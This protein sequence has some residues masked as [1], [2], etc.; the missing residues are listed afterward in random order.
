MLSVSPQFLTTIR[1]SHTV[2]ITADIWFQNTI[3]SRNIPI[4]DGQVTI[5]S[6]TGVRR[7]LDINIPDT[8][9]WGLLSTPG[10]QVRP[11]RGVRYAGGEVE[12]V[13][14]GVFMVD[15]VSRSAA[16]DGTISVSSAPDR[17]SY[18]QRARFETPQ[19][20]IASN[21][22]KQEIARLV[23]GAINVGVTTTATSTALAG[24]LTYEQDREVPIN[25]L[26][27]AIGAEAYFDTAG[28]LVIADAPL[29]GSGAVWSIDAGENGILIDGNRRRD[30]TRTYNV[31]V[32]TVAALDGQVVPE[33][34]VVADTDATS[35]TYIGGAMGRVPYFYESPVFLDTGQMLAAGKAILNKVKGVNAQLDV[36][37]VVNPALDR[38]DVV[39][40]RTA[41]GTAERHMVMGLTIPL[42][43]DGVQ[44]ITTQSSRPDGDVPGGE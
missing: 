9:L 23:T 2:E 8:S 13:P 16:N 20:S 3:Q 36:T 19:S 29:L 30:R 6:G 31:V 43:A 37:S 14:L 33:P 18:V 26:L 10:I 38:G 1:Q 41:D 4:S 32:V 17:W 28:L 15:S 22:A 34:V 44:S 40:V 24:A 27:T 21:T 42:T 5:N 39:I 11:Y 12:K 35:E 25:A 7:T